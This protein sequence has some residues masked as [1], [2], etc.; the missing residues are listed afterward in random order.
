MHGPLGGSTPLSQGGALHLLSSNA[1]ANTLM[2][3]L[4]S[5]SLL[6]GIPGLFWGACISVLTRYSG[7][8]VGSACWLRPHAELVGGSCFCF[9]QRK[10]HLGPTRTWSPPTRNGGCVGPS[11]LAICKGARA[12][13]LAQRGHAAC[14]AR[15]PTMAA[16]PRSR[17][18]ATRYEKNCRTCDCE[19]EFQGP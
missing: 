13:N 16:L 3:S 11:L 9:A 17:G 4:P 18:G 2:G 8:W 15:E 1:Q 6:D 5:T 12:N 19:R 14:A 10:C 7:L